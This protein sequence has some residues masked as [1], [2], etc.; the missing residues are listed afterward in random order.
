MA[1]MF[2]ATMFIFFQMG[3]FSVC[4]CVYK[5][6]LNKKGK[7]E[8]LPFI[9]GFLILPLFKRYIKF[10]STVLVFGKCS[11]FCIGPIIYECDQFSLKFLNCLSGM[12]PLLIP[13]QICLFRCLVLSEYPRCIFQIWRVYFRRDGDFILHLFDLIIWPLK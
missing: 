12:F 6:Y 10:N 3:F 9:F 1:I 2:V 5:A 8:V 7:G 4:V 13:P 11:L